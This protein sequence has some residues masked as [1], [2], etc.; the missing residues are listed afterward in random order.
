MIVFERIINISPATKITA[1]QIINVLETPAFGRLFALLIV[2]S[3]AEFAEFVV[4][5]IPTVFPPVVLFVVVLLP[6]SGF[7]GSSGVVGATTET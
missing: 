2:L 4:F 3:L 7:S 1:K 6:S 5:V